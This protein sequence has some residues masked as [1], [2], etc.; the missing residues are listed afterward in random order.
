M[1][2]CVYSIA[3]NEAKHVKRWFD[4]AQDADYIVIGDTGSTDDTVQISKDLGII[5]FSLNTKP[6]HFANAKNQLLSLCPNADLYV[7]LDVDEVLLPG[8]RNIIESHAPVD[9][10]MVN[11]MR[12]NKELKRISRIHSNKFEWFGCIHEFLNITTGEARVVSTNQI[13]FDHFPDLSKDRSNYFDLLKQS[14]YNEKYKHSRAFNLYQY[15]SMLKNR[16]EYGE[17]L[18]VLQAAMDECRKHAPGNIP[19]IENMI[20]ELENEYDK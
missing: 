5:T 6:F 20:Q 13:L 1:K 3:K 9:L 16:K 8:W 17:A 2:I 4:S 7:C 15:G 19:M 11:F 12:P 10:L 14:V 18:L